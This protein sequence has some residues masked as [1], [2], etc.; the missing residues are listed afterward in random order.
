M[1]PEKDNDSQF[2]HGFWASFLILMVCH[3]VSCRITLN[4]CRVFPCFVEVPQAPVEAVPQQV[5]ME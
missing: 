1:T 2:Y 4:S 3:D 5:G